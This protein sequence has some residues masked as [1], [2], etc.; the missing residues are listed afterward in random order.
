[1]PVGIDIL[2]GAIGVD[3]FIAL[4]DEDESDFDPDQDILA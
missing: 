1:M 2:I 3:T 4:N